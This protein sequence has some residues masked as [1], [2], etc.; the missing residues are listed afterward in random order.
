MLNQRGI[1][2][3]GGS[4]N[5]AANAQTYML[6]ATSDPATSGVPFIQLRACVKQ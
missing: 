6:S 4:N 2:A 5:S 1:A 3:E